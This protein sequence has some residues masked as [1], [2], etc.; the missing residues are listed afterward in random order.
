MPLVLSA[1]SIATLA[2]AALTVWHGASDFGSTAPERLDSTWVSRTPVLACTRPMD[3]LR[4]AKPTYTLRTPTLFCMCLMWRWAGPGC[5]G[6]CPHWEADQSVLTTTSMADVQPRLA[7]MRGAWAAPS[8]LMASAASAA[9]GR[10]CGS[11]RRHRRTSSTAPSGHS[12][13]TLQG[14]RRSWREIEMQAVYILF[15]PLLRSFSL[16]YG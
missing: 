1:I 12:S 13:G 6:R 11:G 3:T 7:C 14:N 2:A 8:A 16:W 4:R 10:S 15:D 9:V 5:C